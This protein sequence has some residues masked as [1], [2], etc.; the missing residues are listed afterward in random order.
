[1]VYNIRALPI[2]TK[3]FFQLATK[4]DLGLN[5]F[6]FNVKTTHLLFAFGDWCQ[7]ECLLPPAYIAITA[8]AREAICIGE[9]HI[10]FHATEK[11]RDFI[12]RNLILLTLSQVHIYMF[13][14]YNFIC[15]RV[16]TMDVG[17]FCGRVLL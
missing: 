9:T 15:M 3:N 16:M 7:T 17:C 2:T 1:M 6:L 8:L 10:A 14:I 13:S 4:I 11:E 5:T 12:A